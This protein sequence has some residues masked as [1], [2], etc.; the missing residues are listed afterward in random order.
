MKICVAN[1]TTEILCILTVYIVA[2]VI[3]IAVDLGTSVK[4]LNAAKHLC[5]QCALSRW[6]CVKTPY[7]SISIAYKFILS[8]Q[9][10]KQQHWKCHNFSETVQEGIHWFLNISS[11]KKGNCTLMK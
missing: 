5:T 6:C 2:V 1:Y 4:A 7:K 3:V 11:R 9:K 10:I 8:L